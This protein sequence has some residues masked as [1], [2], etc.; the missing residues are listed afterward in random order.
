MRQ[1]TGREQGWRME[2]VF[3][4]GGGNIYIFEYEY[5]M[6]FFE[7]GSDPELGVLGSPFPSY[8]ICNKLTDVPRDGQS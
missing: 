4:W 8:S 5:I 1:A 6:F 7:W 2:R 3:F